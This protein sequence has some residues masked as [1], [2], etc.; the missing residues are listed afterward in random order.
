MQQ[1]QRL[2][3]PQA[4]KMM[5]V[6]AKLGGNCNVGS[7][8]ESKAGLKPA[9]TD[10]LAGEELVRTVQ[11]LAS[12]KS[13][14]KSVRRDL[15]NNEMVL[16]PISD[17]ASAKTLDETLC[18]VYEPSMLTSQTLPKDEDWSSKVYCA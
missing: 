9:K 7:L 18:K 14:L 10:P 4:T 5:S 6:F 3:P 17:E 12:V 8:F 16:F 2:R 1:A 15:V 13:A 11:A